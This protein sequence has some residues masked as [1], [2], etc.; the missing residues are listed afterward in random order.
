MP[1]PEHIV[2]IGSS[3]DDRGEPG[4]YEAA[5]Q[6]LATKQ[7]PDGI[8]CF[9]DPIALGAMRAILDAGLRIPEDIAVV[10]CGNVLY[11]DFLRVPLT[12]VDQ[13]SAAIGRIAAE[14]ALALVGTKTPMRP[15]TELISPKLMVRASS[16]RELSHGFSARDAQMKSSRN[17]AS[18]VSRRF[19]LREQPAL[20]GSPGH[21]D[22]QPRCLFRIDPSDLPLSPQP[23]RWPTP[24]ADTGSR[25]QSRY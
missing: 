25:S 20:N 18:A 4:G 11:S 15:R 10:G 23:C 1:L 24:G 17:S 6:L 5:K 13:D 12:S 8:F 2:S 22:N 16:M 21:V 19:A 14:L 3:G 9:N 7:R